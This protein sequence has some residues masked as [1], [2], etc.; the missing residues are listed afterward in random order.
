MD[1][2]FTRDP[3]AAEWVCDCAG[4]PG[5]IL[6]FFP[7]GADGGSGRAGAVPP[8]PMRWRRRRAAP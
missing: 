6:R 1:P 3:I 8:R 4:D 7:K 5:S 2:G